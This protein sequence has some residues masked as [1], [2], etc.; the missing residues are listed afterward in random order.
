MCTWSI[1]IMTPSSPNSPLITAQNILSGQSSTDRLPTNITKNLA[2]IV[3][4]A[5]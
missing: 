4:R 2:N 3:E 1:I 5:T